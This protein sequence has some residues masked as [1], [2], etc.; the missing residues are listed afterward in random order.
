MGLI[1]IAKKI[2]IKLLHKKAR[3]FSMTRLD[4]LATPVRRNGEHIR[5]IVER[6]RKQALEIEN[7]S[8]MS[9]S[10]NSPTDPAAELKRKSRS[11]SQLAGA[12]RRPA[13]RDLSTG[14][15]RGA[16]P[17]NRLKPGMA[18]NT[19]RKSDT[20]KSMS[21]LS[22]SDNET[23]KGRARIE[24]SRKLRQ[25]VKEQLSNSNVTGAILF[26]DLYIIY[27]SLFAP[28]VKKNLFI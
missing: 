3:A 4:Q 19:M 9:L 6:E 26:Y 11:M 24:R 25:Q 7:I 28:S 18:H 17:Q 16:T 20:S 5:A 23:M 1:L 2:H 12:G 13:R 27:L 14:S 22:D 8:R 15:V 21:Q 10:R